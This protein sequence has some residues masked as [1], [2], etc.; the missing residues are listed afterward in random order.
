MEDDGEIGQALAHLFQNVKAQLGLLAG[1]E[2]VSAV[3]G[4]DSNRQRVTTGA[5]YEFLYFFRTSVASVVVRNINFIFN[6]SQSTQ[7]SFN[8]NAIILRHAKN[9]RHR[10][11][12]QVLALT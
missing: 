5:F 8:D 6:T 9:N 7:F 4:A 12:P 10:Q 2:L 3:A 11:L 1:L